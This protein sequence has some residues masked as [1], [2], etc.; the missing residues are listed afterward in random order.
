[1]EMFLNKGPV[2]HPLK[3]GKQKHITDI[4]QNMIYLIET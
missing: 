4:V 3:A 1:M 2:T